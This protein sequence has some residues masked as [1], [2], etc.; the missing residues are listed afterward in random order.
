MGWAVVSLT[1]TCLPD[2]PTICAGSSSGMGPFIGFDEFTNTTNAGGWQYTYEFME[3]LET[4]NGTYVDPTVLAEANA[5]TM[6]VSVTIDEDG[7]CVIDVGDDTCASCSTDPDLCY[8][9]V[10]DADADADDLSQSVTFDCTNVVNGRSSLPKVCE[11]LNTDT[12]FYP[13]MYTSTTTSMDKEETDSNVD[14]V[15]IDNNGNGSDGDYQPDPLPA[16]EAQLCVTNAVGA[17]CPPGGP[18]AIA[19]CASS[20]TG[21]FFNACCPT[22]FAGINMGTSTTDTNKFE[23]MITNG[24]GVAE[25]AMCVVNSNQQGCNI[26]GVSGNTPTDSQPLALP[27]GVDGPCLEMEAGASCSMTQGTCNT[28]L[29]GTSGQDFDVCCPNCA[30]GT[31]LPGQSCKVILPDPGACGLIIVDSSTS[32]SSSTSTTSNGDASSST[33]TTSSSTT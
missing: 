26:F 3:G 27:A 22:E 15:T 17:T 8:N 28:A 4:Y 21:G 23:M 16:N 1:V 24:L 11:S 13:L 7:T 33:T 20:D 10:T 32:S 18:P 9:I 5:T 25:S 14:G 6:E 19:C 2:A 29:D 30:R 12:V 31:Y